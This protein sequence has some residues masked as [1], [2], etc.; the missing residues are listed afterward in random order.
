MTRTA[1]RAVS[2]ENHKK[3]GPVRGLHVSQVIRPKT[4]YVPTRNAY[5]PTRN[6]YGK[7][8]LKEFCYCK[9]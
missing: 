8:D 3:E 5:G 9:S 6:A 7:I 4:T 2:L 1:P